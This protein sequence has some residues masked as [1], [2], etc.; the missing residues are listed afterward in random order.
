MFERF[1]HDRGQ[2]R[3]STSFN[4]LPEKTTVDLSKANDELL[5]PNVMGEPAFRT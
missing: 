2:G 1:E 5:L 4:V 3:G